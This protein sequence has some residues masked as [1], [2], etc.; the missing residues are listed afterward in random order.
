[1]KKLLFALV[2]IAAIV[3]LS[4]FSTY[5]V[6]RDQIASRRAGVEQAWTHVNEAMLRRN[7]LVPSMLAAVR[8]TAARHRDAAG[9]VRQANV[10]MLAAASPQATIDASHRLETA[11]ATLISAAQDDPDLLVNRRFFVLQ[12]KWAAATNRISEERVKYDEEVRDYNGFIAEFPNRIFARWG[13]FTPAD[14]YFSATPD[15]TA[16]TAALFGN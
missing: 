16:K 13:E 10:D 11:M 2:L 5:A 1:M 8:G 4:V 6:R 12:D 7:D 9:E 3:G 14:N 15:S